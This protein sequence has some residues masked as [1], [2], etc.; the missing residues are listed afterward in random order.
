MAL[1]DDLIKIVIYEDDP[2]KDRKFEDYAQTIPSLCTESTGY[3]LTGV[4]N[5]GVSKSTALAWLGER[6]G[7]ERFKIC[8]F[9]DYD[10]DISLFEASG[11]SVAV[12]NATDL[13]K[14]YATYLTRSNN[15]DGVA[16]FIETYLLKN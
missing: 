4:F 7:I 2:V 3:G 6:L 11:I 1:D 12:E 13:V 8:A 9:G 15:Q 10:N 16:R 14:S 5:K